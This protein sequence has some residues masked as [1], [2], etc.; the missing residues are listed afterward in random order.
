MNCASYHSA[1]A[2]RRFSA[3][4]CLKIYLRST[5][6]ESKLNRLALANIKD[7][8]IDVEKGVNIFSHK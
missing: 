4:R 3:M 2:E 1:T 7:K 8:A 5:M 6:R